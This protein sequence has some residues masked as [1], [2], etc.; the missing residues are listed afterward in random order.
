MKKPIACN[1]KLI[2]LLTHC[3]LF[4]TLFCQAYFKCSPCETRCEVLQHVIHDT[5]LVRFF[6]LK[7]YSDSA[8]IIIDMNNFFNGCVV[9]NVIG[10]KV[11]IL[12]DSLLA[13]QASNLNYLVY[14]DSV[15]KTKCIISIYHKKTHGLGWVELKRQNGKFFS[16]KSALGV[17]D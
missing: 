13:N 10:R 17:I 12:H 1:K 15:T 9:E 8:I 7:R 16:I 14:S 4:H 6:N 3:L 5:V 11:L 2:L